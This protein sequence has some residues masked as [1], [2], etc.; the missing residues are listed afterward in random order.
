MAQ[1]RLVVTMEAKDQLSPALKKAGDQAAKT[2]KEIEK[3]TSADISGFGRSMLRGAT[4]LATGL[5]GLAKASSDLAEAQN[6]SNQIFGDAAPAINQYAKAAATAIGMSER[7]ALD[8]AA[9]VGIFGQR[10]ELTG[11]DLARFSTNLVTLAADMASIKNTKPEEAVTAIAAAMRNEYEP[12]RRYGVVLNDV[13]L[14]AR[15]LKMGLYDGTGQLTQQQKIIAV[16]AELYD[17]LGFAIGDFSRT[18][19]ELANQTRIAQAQFEN[20][21]ANLGDSLRPTFI[22]LTSTANA[23]LEMFQKVPEP[24]KNIAANVALLGTGTL[25]VGGAMLF[26]AGKIGEM[27]TQ[28]RDYSA[29][30]KQARAD[31]NKFATGA[32]SMMTAVAGVGIAVAGLQVIGDIYNEIID[33]SGQATNAVERFNIAVAKGDDAGILEQFQALGEAERA[34]FRLGDVWEVAGDKF[35]ATAS[36]V[37]VEIENMDRAF[38]KIAESSPEAGAQLIRALEGEQAAVAKNSDR[39]NELQHILDRYRPRVEQTIDSQI[40]LGNSTQFSEETLAQFSDT[41]LVAE[42]TTDDLKKTI[43]E[44]AEKMRE[45]AKNLDEAEKATDTAAETAEAFGDALEKSIGTSD[46]VENAIDIK[47]AIAD[48]GT[49]WRDSEGAIKDGALSL[50]MNTQAGRDNIAA[51]DEIAQKAGEDLARVY[52]ETGGS[53]EEVTK[54]ADEWTWALIGEAAAAGASQEQ[55]DAMIATMNLTPE[56]I[57]TAIKLKDDEVALKKLEIL[58]LEMDKIPPSIATAIQA[59]MDEGDFTAAYQIASNWIAG[60]P[61]DFQTEV[62]DPSTEVVEGINTAQ[63]VADKNPVSV[64]TQAEEVSN[65]PSVWDK[66]FGFF[67][68]TPVT[69]TIETKPGDIAGPVGEN[70]AYAENNPPET[71]IETKPGN[72]RAIWAQIDGYTRM[73]Q[74]QTTIKTLPGLYHITW[75]MIAL[76]FAAKPVML[77]VNTKPGNLGATWGMIAFYFAVRPVTVPVRPDPR[78][79]GEAWSQIQNYFNGRPITVRV[80]TVAGSTAAIPQAGGTAA[81][82]QSEAAAMSAMGLV[83]T[84]TGTL[85]AAPAPVTAGFAAP[86]STPSVINVTVNMPHGTN[87]AKVVDMLKRYQRSNGGGRNLPRR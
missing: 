4:S 47:N 46:A 7:A 11:T 83:A 64:P 22:K 77:T 56:A 13:V 35:S 80:N 1:E 14:K 65:L 69:S 43:E 54:K 55:I 76:Y 12:I 75:A 86:T 66:A 61:L 78:N 19:G 30:L 31:G 20:L 24:V 25:A 42:E 81:I 57:E 50:D 8:A 58:N 32:S 72:Y 48:L 27:I 36:G 38:K 21:Q 23:A 51:I 37:N 84:P 60:R 40:A 82:P 70:A 85:L 2:A 45:Y 15:A 18:Q 3:I 73:H 44:A 68:D 28:V 29:R 39:W 17:Q 67:N 53:I 49:S 63:G 6:F 33:V 34:A 9:S 87:E 62:D 26:A 71:T 52:T 59:E 16:N 74:P 10:I 41:S 79:L 5:Y